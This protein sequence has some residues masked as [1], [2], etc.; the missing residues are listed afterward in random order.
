MTGLLQLARGMDW[1]ST[2]LSKVAGWAVLAAALISAGNA[3][4]R[5]GLDMSSNAWLEIQWY[6]FGT[7]VMLGAPVVL[8]LNEHVRVDIIY[9]KLRGRGPV[10]VDLFGLIFFLLPVMGL[11]TWLT[12]PFF[13]NMYVTK[14]MSG[15]IGGLIRWPAALLLPVGFG[16]VFLQGLAEIVKRVAYLTG[17]LQISTHYEK[18]IQ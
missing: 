13:W 12:W 17:H 15:N 3:L 7:T 1:V 11:L 16:A 2:K 18:P 8:K 5:Y 4:V 9:G 14:E 10:F 6:L